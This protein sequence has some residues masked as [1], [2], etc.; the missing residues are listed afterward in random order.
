MIKLKVILDTISQKYFEGA[1]LLM[2]L[3]TNMPFKLWITAFLFLTECMYA[4]PVIRQIE[5]ITRYQ[6]QQNIYEEQSKER[7]SETAIYTELSAIPLSRES[8]VSQ[9]CIQIESIDTEGITLIDKEELEVL[10]QP[11]LHRCDSMEDINT[12]V[13]KINNIYIQKAYV[14]SR[15][16]IKPQDLSK[17][18]LEIVAMEGKVEKISGSNISTV[19]VFPTMEGEILDLRDLEMGLEQLNRLQSVEATMQINPGDEE[20]FSK[21]VIIGKKM[22]SV[23]HGNLGVN[24]YGTKKS[25]RYQFSGSVGWDDPLGIN[26]LLTVNLNTTDKQSNDNNSIG[27]SISYALPVG[28]SYLEISYF[29]F[30]YDQIVNGLNRDYQSKGDTET[31]QIKTEYKLFHSKEQ[32]G[33]FDISLLRK[34]N[35]NYL[36]DVFLDTSSNKLTILRF[37]YTHHYAAPT[38]DGYVTLRYLRGLEW[39]G[40]R[41]AA[42]TDPTFNKYT[43]DMSY[44]KGINSKGIPTFYN[45]SFYGQYAKKGIVGSEQI[46]IGGPYSVR[47]FTSEGQ[48]SGNKG[49]YVRNELAFV[50]RFEKGTLSPY[51]G[52]DY[53]VVTHN[54]ESYGGHILGLTFG[55]RFNFY[56]CLL[57]LSYSLPVIDSNRVIYRANGDVIHKTNSPFSGFSLLYRF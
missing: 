25:G 46:G 53:G 39:F 51:L 44:N 36:E 17:E 48:I 24:N 10:I 52:L 57:D 4:L 43:L 55:S 6:D 21:I 19:L 33:K 1:S 8:N 5:D 12:L 40:A 38:W 26:D 3:T 20:G 28:R 9:A 45:F 42:L 27:N 34:K 30:D 47:G 41:A 50:Q 13:K 37:S 2:K 15:A 16:Y 49:F 22:G 32:K 11:Y 14:T 54:D 29:R 18:H 35:D 31:F 23:L 7:R 56:D